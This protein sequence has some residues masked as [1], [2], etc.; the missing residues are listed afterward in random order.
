MIYKSEEGARAVEERYRAYLARWPV[1]SEQLRL[2]TRQ[3]ET[4]VV[5]CGPPDAPPLLLFHGSAANTAMWIGEA[6]DWSRHFRVYAVDMIGEPGL[7]APARPPMTSD[8][9]ARWLD[10]VLDG[11][12]VERASIV[13]VSLGGWLGV[14]YASRLP[15]RV[16]RLALLCP[17]GIGKL[18]SGVLIAALSLSLLGG[19][20]GRSKAMH[21]ILG[22]KP[23]PSARQSPQTRAFVEFILLINKYFLPRRHLPVFGDDVL[24]RLTMPVLAVVGDRDAILDSHQTRRRLERLA[25]HATVRMLPD[26]GHY[27]QGQTPQILEFLRAPEGSRA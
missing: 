6:A 20:W 26:A 17:G 22:T 4:F 21:L 25:P 1:P 10:D 2:P 7:S 23:E 27:L 14:D 9:Y 18:K 11:L 3:G 12:G 5:A 19:A 16:E 13:G 24:R 15:E 8:A